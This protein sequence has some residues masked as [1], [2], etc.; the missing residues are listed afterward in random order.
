M[1]EAW[2]VPILI[3]VAGAA[4]LIAFMRAVATPTCRVAWKSFRCPLKKRHV[5]V[6]FLADRFRQDRYCDVLSCSAFGAP[7]QV[8]CDKHC[9]DSPEVYQAPMAEEMD[10]TAE[11]VRHCTPAARHRQEGDTSCQPTNAIPKRG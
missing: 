9:L 2:I 7:W 6:G 5:T 1:I 11:H 10:A 3:V 4:L 8:S